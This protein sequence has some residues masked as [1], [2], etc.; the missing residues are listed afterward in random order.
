MRITLKYIHSC[1]TGFKDASRPCCEVAS[2]NE[3][4][5]GVL[6][7]RGGQACADRSS[8]VFFDGL[9]PTEAVNLQIATKAYESDLKSEV[10]PTNVKNLSNVYI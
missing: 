10:Y 2:I 3:G 6:C 5:N 1:F 9:H 7:K 8:H 4:G